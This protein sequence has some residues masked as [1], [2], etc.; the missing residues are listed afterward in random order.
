MKKISNKTGADSP[1][2]KKDYFEIVRNTP[3]HLKKKFS[4]TDFHSMI[5]ALREQREKKS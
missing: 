4:M 3:P 5:E 2:V 1:D